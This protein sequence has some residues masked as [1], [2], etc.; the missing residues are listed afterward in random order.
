MPLWENL[1]KTNNRNAAKCYL[2]NSIANSSICDIDVYIYSK[3]DIIKYPTKY[4]AQY[5]YKLLITLAAK[6]H[7]RCV[8][9]I[10][11]RLLCCIRLLVENKLH[12]TVLKC[13]QIRPLSVVDSHEFVATNIHFHERLAV[14]SFMDVVVHWISCDQF[15]GKTIISSA[16]KENDVHRCCWPAFPHYLHT[17]KWQTDLSQFTTQTSGQCAI[18]KRT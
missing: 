13:Q 15:S 3:R 8:T 14:F 5:I 6:H 12:S 9:C 16:F 18:Q 1:T 11:S 2:H 10:N 17:N 4:H 7:W